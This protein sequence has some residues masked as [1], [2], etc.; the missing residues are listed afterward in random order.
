M[1][2]FTFCNSLIM[3]SGEQYVIWPAFG[4]A[5]VWKTKTDYRNHVLAKIPIKTVYYKKCLLLLRKCSVASTMLIEIIIQSV[6]EF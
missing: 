3:H 1:Y 5:V 6:P 4:K 2:N